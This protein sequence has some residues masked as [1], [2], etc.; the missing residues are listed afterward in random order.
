MS[1]I[2]ASALNLSPARFLTLLAIAPYR[3]DRLTLSIGAAGLCLAIYGAIRGDRAVRR[4]SFTMVAVLCIVAAGPCT[5][6]F[7][8]LFDYL[9]GFSLF[10][11]IG[12]MGILAVMF[13]AMLAAIGLDTLILNRRD[14]AALLAPIIVQWGC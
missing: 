3:G 7:G 6:I 4:F 12:R 2:D 9:P 10:R 5:P 8:W 11:V 13:M 1:L 14:R